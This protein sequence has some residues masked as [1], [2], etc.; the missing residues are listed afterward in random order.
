MIYTD[1]SILHKNELILDTA[2]QQ[3]NES[4]LIAHIN[5]SCELNALCARFLFSSWCLLVH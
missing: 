3:P 2:S 1:H 5:Q 4:D